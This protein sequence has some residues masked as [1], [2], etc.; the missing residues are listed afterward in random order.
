MQTAGSRLLVVCFTNSWSDP[1]KRITTFYE[2]LPIQ[3]PN[4]L[5]ISVDADLARD[6][7][8]IEHLPGVPTFK[9]WKAG[10]VVTQFSGPDVEKLRKIIDENK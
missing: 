10:K 3:Y 2:G 5:F 8:E 4:V 9:F 7:P 1:C 6:H